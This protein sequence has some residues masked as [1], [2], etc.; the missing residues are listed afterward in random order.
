MIK[1]KNHKE[2]EIPKVIE[3]NPSSI[4]A[5]LE[6]LLQMAKDGQIESFLFAGFSPKN[7]I[8][9]SKA[10]LDVIGQ[11][12]LVAFLQT[13]TTIRAISEMFIIESDDMDDLDDDECTC[14]DFYC[15]DCET[16]DPDEC[17]CD[18]DDDE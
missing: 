11:Q 18:K 6:K 15:D 5:S 10:E 13:E 3:L 14:E 9:S 1:K 8:I 12:H 4:I 17:T 2:K 16:D 7:L